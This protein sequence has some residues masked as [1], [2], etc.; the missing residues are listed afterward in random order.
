MGF[1]LEGAKA[2]RLPGDVRQRVGGEEGHGRFV[3]LDEPYG[4]LTTSL[5]VEENG[6]VQAARS[7]PPSQPGT[8]HPGAAEVRAVRPEELT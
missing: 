6:H 1:I 4:V 2:K 7:R 3:S 8:Q 5:G